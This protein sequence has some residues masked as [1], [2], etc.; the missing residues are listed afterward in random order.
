MN[1]PSVKQIS[2]IQYNNSHRFLLDLRDIHLFL[3]WNLLLHVGKTD[4]AI[5]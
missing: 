3:N 4:F 2:P 5:D 1:T